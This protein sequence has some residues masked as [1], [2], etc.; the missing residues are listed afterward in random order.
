VVLQDDH[1]TFGQRRHAFRRPLMAEHRGR[2]Q[3]GLNQA[4]GVALAFGDEHGSAG[5]GVH[6]CR[7]VVD[8]AA[9]AGTE[10]VFAVRLVV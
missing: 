3:S 5:P 7:P 1:V 8:H 6:N 10:Q 2:Q 9:G 4:F